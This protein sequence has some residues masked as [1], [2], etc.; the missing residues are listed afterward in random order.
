MVTNHPVEILTSLP[1][2]VI[3]YGI[4]LGLFVT[5]LPTLLLI[6]SIEYIGTT[7]SAIISSISP[8]VTIL[9]SV[10][11]LNEYLSAIQWLGCFL[12]ILGVML[13]TIKIK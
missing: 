6:L 3:W 5:V 13:I 9:L 1:I 11:L 4:C 2:E 10:L 8:I 12:N 7:K